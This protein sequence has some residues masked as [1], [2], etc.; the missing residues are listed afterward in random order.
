ME[1]NKNIL[2]NTEQTEEQIH[3]PKNTKQ[4]TVL[5]TVISIAL[6]FL[7]YFGGNGLMNMINRPYLM[8]QNAE[9]ITEELLEQ[10]YEYAFVSKEYGLVYENSRLE[11]NESGYKVSILFSGVDDIEG[12]AE[13]GILFEFGNPIEDVDDEFYPYIDNY[14]LPEYIIATKYVDNDEPSNEMLI[15]EYEG[16]LYAEFQS[17]GAIVPTEVKILFDGCEKVY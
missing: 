7:I 12:F 10:Y 6:F 9:G 8:I 11:K 5:Y 4:Q 16:K 1:D 14:N 15:F 17:Y 3:I 13:N 2:E